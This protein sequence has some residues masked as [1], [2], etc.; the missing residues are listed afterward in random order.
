MQQSPQVSRPVGFVAHKSEYA[1]K[2]KND[3]FPGRK[4]AQAL[5]SKEK[6]YYHLF[7]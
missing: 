7:S 6:M 3:G 5:D 1:W 2:G 4:P